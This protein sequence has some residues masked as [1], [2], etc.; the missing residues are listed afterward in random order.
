MRVERALEVARHA[1]AD[2]L[3][4]SHPSSVAWLTGYAAEIETGPNPFALSP[5]VV[6]ADGARMLVV[7]EDEAE[8]AAETGCDVVAYPGFGLGP[9]DPVGGA[10][11]ALARALE[12]RRVA[13]EAGSLPA[14]LAAGLDQVDVTAALAAERA[15][16]DADEIARVRAA[17]ALC[18]A[19]QRAAREA[20]R[21]G[22]TEL[23]VWAAVRA[24]IERAAGARV[25]L[26]ADLVSGPRTADVGG[27]PGGRELRDGDLVLVDLVPRRD[28]YW[29][30]SCAT[31]AVGEPGETARARHRA[32]REALARGVEAVRPGVR[33]GD[34]DA[35]VRS[36]LDYPHHTGHGIGAAWHEE[37]RIVPG[38]ETMLEAGMVV[39]LEPGSYGDGEGV[40]VEQVLLVIADGCELLSGHEL[41][42]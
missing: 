26:L 19:G 11:R 5:L 39:A 37:P 3:L 42:L 41:A 4:A 36:G 24:A 27:P 33:A 22:A 40:R 7:S 25:P 38:A 31:V 17:I 35:L 10:A 16:K 14:A 1:G 6:L 12:G 30:D 13:V 32:A 34:L 20:A 18:D 9:V 15:V 29:G 2:A 28:G 8:A 21:A 23:D